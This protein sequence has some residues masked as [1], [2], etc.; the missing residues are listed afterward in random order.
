MSKWA[1]PSP[2]GGLIIDSIMRDH[3]VVSMQF[4]SRDKDNIKVSL[5]P[6]SSNEEESALY[7][8]SSFSKTDTLLQIEKDQAISQIRWLKVPGTMCEGIFFSSKQA[9]KS[10]IPIMMNA[11]MPGPFS[12]GQIYSSKFLFEFIQDNQLL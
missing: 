12:V 3:Y 5:T 6:P 4:N 7:S 8:L 10:F 9:A 1:I 11:R 2:S